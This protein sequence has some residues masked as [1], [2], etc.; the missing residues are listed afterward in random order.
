[1]VTTLKTQMLRRF[2]NVADND[3]LTQATFLDLRFKK[4][5]FTKES[6]FEATYNTMRNKLATVNISTPV[7]HKKDSKVKIQMQILPSCGESS[8]KK[9]NRYW[10]KTIQRQLGLLKWINTCKNL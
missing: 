1:M 5:G 2:K 10:K 7:S 9:L 4:H 8:I 3:L 6:K